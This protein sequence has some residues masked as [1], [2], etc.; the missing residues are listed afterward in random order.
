MYQTLAPSAADWNRVVW[1]SWVPVRHDGSFTIEAWPEGELIQVTALCDGFI[2][3]SGRAPAAV[4]DRRDPAS[5][6]FQRPQVFDPSDQQPIAVSMEP[7]VRCVVTAVDEDDKPVAGIRIA[8]WPNVGWWNDGSQIYCGTLVRSERQIRLRDYDASIDAPF[9][10]PFEAVTD[11][12]GSATLELPAGREQ[13]TVVADLYEL[14]IML[15]HRHASI[16]LVAGKTTQTTLRL[17]P[18]G[19]ERLGEWGKLAG[20]VF[21]CST[22]EGRRICALPEV[23]QKMRE[24]TLRFRDAKSQRDPQLLAEAYTLVADAFANVGDLAESVKWR[25][26]SSAFRLPGCCAA[27]LAE[28]PWRWELRPEERRPK[29]QLVP[30]AFHR[31]CTTKDGWHLL[32]DKR[33]LAPIGRHLSATTNRPLDPTSGH[34]L[35]QFR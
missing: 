26:W 21:G 7:L 3:T 1:F 2:A 34:Q 16:E 13:V 20:V 25:R 35:G 24:F 12:T 14:P 15:G 33:W 9:P 30:P 19:T 27:K 10:P 31:R 23:N 32:A 17:Q 11:G 22:R 6:R 18:K 4:V 8:S 28:A 29:S 5:D